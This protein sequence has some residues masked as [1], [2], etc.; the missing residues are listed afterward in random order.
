MM[1]QVG[2]EEHKKEYKQ[3]LANL[4]GFWL[5]PYLKSGVIKNKDTFKAL[6]R[7]LCHNLLK[8]RNQEY[9]KFVTVSSSRSWPLW[10]GKI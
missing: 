3:R 8:R 9:G 1:A 7:D 2:S 10:P 4:V 6:N 5:S